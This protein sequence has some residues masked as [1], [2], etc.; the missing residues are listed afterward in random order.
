MGHEETCVARVPIF[1][2]LTPDQQ[3]EVARF[4]RPIRVAAGEA[5]YAP[6]RPV[7]RLMVV[8]EGSVKISHIS[9]AGIERIVRVLKPGDVAGE[10]AF[11]TGRWPDHFAIAMTPAEMCVFDHDRL[12]AL[13]RDLPDIALRMLQT[14]STRLASAERLLAAITSSDVGARVA[15]YLLDLPAAP[16]SDGAVVV[17]LPMAKKDVASYLGTTPETLSRRLASLADDGV[18]RLGRGSEITITDV[19]GLSGR[20]VV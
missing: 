11:L 6:G 3:M 17:H 9:P 4:A 14:L 10:S 20:A 13:V 2:G 12:A 5:L 8:H 16:G 15:A 19:D 18:I 1:A 7:S